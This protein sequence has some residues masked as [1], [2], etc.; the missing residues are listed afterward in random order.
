MSGV[1]KLAEGLRSFARLRQAI[2]DLDKKIQ[3][4]VANDVTGYLNM[5]A[6]DAFRAG[7]TV[8]ETPRPIGVNGNFLTL[9]DTGTVEE[10]LMFKSDG[11]TVRASLGT[12][13]AKYLI[14]K[15][16]ILPFPGDIPFAWRDKI[17]QIVREYREDFEREAAR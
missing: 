8:Y 4:G 3:Q 2:A 13:Y 9:K 6:P 17:E 14:G 15:Y 12:T 16:K 7:R 11:R 10:R 5:V 1:K